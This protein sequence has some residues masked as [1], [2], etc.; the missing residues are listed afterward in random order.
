M[1]NDPKTVPARVAF[2]QESAELTAGSRDKVYGDPSINL[3]LAGQLKALVRRY[4]QREMPATEVEALD[5]VLQ[6]VARAYTGSGYHRDNYVDG[7][8]Y[9]AI[10]GEAAQLH[11]WDT[12]EA[13]KTAS[14]AEG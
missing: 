14:P 1:H 10:A 4:Q 13:P 2:L 3:S 11:H 12:I 6:K 5:N 9:F 8:A 7:A